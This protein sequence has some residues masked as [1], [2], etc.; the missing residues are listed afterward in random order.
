M[1]SCSA[2]STLINTTICLKI[3]LCVL[4][5]IFYNAHVLLGSW[6]ILC[7]KVLFNAKTKLTSTFKPNLMF[8]PMLN[9][10]TVLLALSYVV[11]TNLVADCSRYVHSSRCGVTI[12]C[13]AHTVNAS[14]CKRTQENVKRFTES[15]RP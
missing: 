7:P 12:Y 13:H 9:C 14:N 2:N 1:T 4:S 11:R 6:H 15:V 10:M 3:I 5:L 8:I